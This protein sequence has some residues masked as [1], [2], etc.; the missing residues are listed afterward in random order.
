MILLE[1]AFRE[2]DE[3]KSGSKDRNWKLRWDEERTI[4]SII[5][6]KWFETGGKEFS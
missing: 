6:W 1:D 5:T 3:G 4:V 2:Y